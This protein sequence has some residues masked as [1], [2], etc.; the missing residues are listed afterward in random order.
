MGINPPRTY[1]RAKHTAP[2]HPRRKSNR[3][4]LKTKKH[5]VGNGLKCRSAKQRHPT[6]QHAGCPLRKILKICCRGGVSP[7]VNLCK[8][9]SGGEILPLRK[10]YKDTL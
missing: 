8:T 1:I 7:P 10:I 5:I 9:L 4:A 2:I 3:L 6:E